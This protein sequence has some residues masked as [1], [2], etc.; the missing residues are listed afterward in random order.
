[1][2]VTLRLY[3][4]GTF[5]SAVGDFAGMSQT[6]VSRVF[7]RVSEV[8]ASHTQDYIR[9]PETDDERME[10][11]RLF[12]LMKKFPRTIGAIDCT[13]IKILSPGGTDAETY[14]NRKGFF[15][16]NVQTIAS[17]DMKVINLV[18]RWP[19][20]THDQNIFK[21]SNIH[22]RFTNVD[23]GHYILVGDSGYK[24]TKFLATPFIDSEV[25]G[26]PVR[27]LYN[28]SQIRTRVVVERR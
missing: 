5:Q 16:L 19:G 17:A 12:Y 13:H 25:G 14:R 23:F 1:M 9:M 28:I 7:R 2:L 6:S 26:D 15:S 11:S 21:D 18:V 22:Y 8:L 10:A 20:S 24:N 27:T 3:A 4:S